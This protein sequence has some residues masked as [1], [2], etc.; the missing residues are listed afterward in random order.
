[1]YIHDDIQHPFQHDPENPNHPQHPDNPVNQLIASG[2]LVNPNAGGLK[3][4]GGGMKSSGGLKGSGGLKKTVGTG[5]P[6]L[7]STSTSN[8]TSTTSAGSDTNFLSKD[9]PL[10]LPLHEKGSHGISMVV[11]DHKEQGRHEEVHDQNGNEVHRDD[12]ALITP[13]R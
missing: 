12:H 4:S 6:T 8:S 5:S 11:L 9:P 1:M 7:T 10:D 13:A 2:G 3:S